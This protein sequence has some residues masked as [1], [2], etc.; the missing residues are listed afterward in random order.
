MKSYSPPL[1]FHCF[2]MRLYTSSRSSSAC[3]G[4]TS[5]V[6]M[7]RR[8]STNTVP[9][10]L[11]RC[12][13]S[14]QNSF[15]ALWMTTGTTGTLVSIASLNGPFL[16]SYR[17]GGNSS[18]ICPSGKMT[19]LRPL[20]IQASACLNALNADILLF[21]FSGMSMVR[22]KSPVTGLLRSSLFPMKAKSVGQRSTIA[23]MSRLEVW[24]AQR[25]HGLDQSTVVS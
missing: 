9:G 15:H 12:L 20:R 22:K 17:W 2:F 1:L 14:S 13:A 23:V 3:S 10:R 7:G 5:V 6:S 24:L 4:P 16:K 18:P 8:T 25:I 19:T 21:R 11:P